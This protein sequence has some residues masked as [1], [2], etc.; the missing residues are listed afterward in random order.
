MGSGDIEYY[1]E[2]QLSKRILGSGN[3]K[4]RGAAP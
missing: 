3:I 1:G 4:H 2:P